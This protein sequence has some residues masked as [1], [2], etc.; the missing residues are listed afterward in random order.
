VAFLPPPDFTVHPTP[1]EFAT[2]F[3][4]SLF[5]SLILS[6]GHPRLQVFLASRQLQMLGHGTS[7]AEL[8]LPICIEARTTVGR[9]HSCWHGLLPIPLSWLFN[10]LV[11]SRCVTDLIDQ[12]RWYSLR[13]HNTCCFDFS[14]Y[15]PFAMHLDIYICLDRKAK[16]TSIMKQMEYSGVSNDKIK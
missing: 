11:H 12:Q 14:R 15:V 5:S 10:N 16:M 1:Q 7:H 13:F 8:K 4:H 2:L 3:L 9:V 6:S